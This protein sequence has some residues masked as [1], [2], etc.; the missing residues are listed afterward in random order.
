[1]ESEAITGR[2]SDEQQPKVID[3]NIHYDI[4]GIPVCCRSFDLDTL[5]SGLAYRA[6]P[7]DVFIVTMPRSGTTWMETIVYSVFQMGRAFDDDFDDFI[8]RTPFL[9][10]HGSLGIE[11]M[12]R[13]GS[14]KTHLPLN[15]IPQHR[16]AKYICVVRN[17]KDMC[18][19]FYKFVRSIPGVAH[20][21]VSFEIYFNLFLDGQVTYGDY[22]DHVLQTWSH[23][24][25]P[26]VLFII[27]EDMKKDI[28]PVIRRVADFLGVKMTPELLE[29]I[30]TVTSLTI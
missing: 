7:G 5:R 4:E 11:T 15:I 21:D 19:S 9:E 29:R 30:I 12:R 25:D 26:N 10:Q 14:I 8:A 28:R 24:D 18:T 20:S 17:P 13:P 1:M 23:K 27:Y 22:F 16:E 6:R 3:H 2:K